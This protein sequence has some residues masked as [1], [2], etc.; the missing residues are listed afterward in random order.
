MPLSVALV[1]LTALYTLVYYL[2]ITAGLDYKKSLLYTFLVVEAF[3]LLYSPLARILR[4]RARARTYR[5][6]VNDLR[7]MARDGAKNNRTP[8]S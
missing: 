7:R 8:S 2:S 1:R 6:A 3:I 4:Q 5:Q